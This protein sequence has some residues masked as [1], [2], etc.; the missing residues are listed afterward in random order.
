[1]VY[2]WDQN[3]SCDH[4]KKQL[5]LKNLASHNKTYHNGA[6]MKYTS[7]TSK[8]LKEMFNNANG[9]R[10]LCDPESSSSSAA[11]VD[12]IKKPKNDSTEETILIEKSLIDKTAATSDGS[13]NSDESKS[14]E[15]DNKT[16]ELSEIKKEL[17]KLV[18]HSDF[19]LQFCAI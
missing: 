16:D 12:S 15:K 5:L 7:T 4:C 11:E 18:K 2:L 6:P 17:Q 1:M 3:V 19:L 8:S 13:D 9:K 14:E 10:K